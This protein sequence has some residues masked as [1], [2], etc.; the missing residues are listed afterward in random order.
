MNNIVR[1]LNYNTQLQPDM[2]DHMY[3]VA[4]KYTCNINLDVQIDSRSLSV[5]YSN[6]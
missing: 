1:D 4:I 6:S 2:P 3:T 5:N